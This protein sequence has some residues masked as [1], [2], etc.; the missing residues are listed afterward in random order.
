MPPQSDNDMN[1]PSEPYDK[2]LKFNIENDNFSS[3]E[4]KDF[5]AFLFTNGKRFSVT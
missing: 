4:I 2:H 3:A 5:E 1:D